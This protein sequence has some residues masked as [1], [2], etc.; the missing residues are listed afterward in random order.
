MFDI[1]KKS[2]DKS[3]G[4]VKS[5]RD[6]LLRFIKKELQK[7]EGGEG[8]NIK[9]IHLFISADSSSKH[10]YEAAVYADDENKFKNEV[11]KI[12]DDYALDLPKT[13]AM[14]TEFC[15]DIPPEAIGIEGLDA[16]LF[17]RTKDNT[18][19]KSATAYIRVLNGEAEKKE[20]TLTSADGK[21]NIGREKKVQVSDGFFRL[22]HI[23]FPGDSSNESNKYISRQHAHIEWS[24]DHNSFM[25]YADEGG[26][27]P[28]NK[29]KIRSAKDETLNKLNSTQI[30]HKLD[31]GDQV[32]LGESAV[33][34]FSYTPEAK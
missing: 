3:T 25:F 33:I 28:T 29:V 21:V 13:W 8:R 1:F 7:A 9:G 12:A 31:E 10:V 5:V 24:N 16:A 19:Q 14:E 17:I 30:G 34:E 15:T 26:V 4:D 11:Q 27:P 18:I 22:N 32:I 20:Y 6:T 2:D 23:A